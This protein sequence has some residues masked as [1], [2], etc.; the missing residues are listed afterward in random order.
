MATEL[1][2]KIKVIEVLIADD[3]P[4]VRGG[5][6]AALDH[7]P[8]IRVVGEACNGLEAVAKAVNL[9]PDVIILDIYMP[10]LNGLEAMS[11]MKKELPDAKFIVMT[12]SDEEENFFQAIKR[13][14]SSYLL[15]SATIQEVEEAVRKT[16][17]GETL[18][19]AHFTAKLMAEF[20]NKSEINL[21]ER[22]ND[23]LQ[24]IGEGLSN[25]EIGRRLFISESTVR[26]HTQRLLDKLH[27]RNRAEAIAYA[28]RHQITSRYNLR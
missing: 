16:A 11:A 21:S 19:S 22:E 10:N 9:K 8:D 28:T 27:L 6:K 24:L 15:K 25:S 20:R 4:V 3:H 2:A 1:N 13:G 7:T 12:V 26:T 5:L 17:N 23:V 14:A 18:L